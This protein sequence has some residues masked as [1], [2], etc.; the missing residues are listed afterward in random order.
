MPEPVT[1]VHSSVTWEMSRAAPAV[2]VTARE[3][4]AAET[5]SIQEESGR[6]LFPKVS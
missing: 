1:A 5:S 4:D 3:G 2:K 6:V